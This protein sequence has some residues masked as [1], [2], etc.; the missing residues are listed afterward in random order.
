MGIDCIYIS[1]ACDSINTGIEDQTIDNAVIIY[2]N[3][4]FDQLNITTFN[5]E[6]SEIILYDISSRIILQKSFINSTAINSAQL[7][8]GIYLYELRNKMG[9][10]KKGK[11]IKN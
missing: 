5:N 7:S 3:P 6:L 10:Y 2:P 8:K 9:V 4:V 1:S 11:V